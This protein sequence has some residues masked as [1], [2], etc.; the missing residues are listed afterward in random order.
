MDGNLEGN[1][2]RK[3]KKLRCLQIPKFK[4]CDIRKMTNINGKLNKQ[5]DGQSNAYRMDPSRQTPATSSG[6]VLEA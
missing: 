5:K 4:K 2:N 3:L 6:E 1:E